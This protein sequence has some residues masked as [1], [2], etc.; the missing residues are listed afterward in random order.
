MKKILLYSLILVSPFLLVIFVNET[1][2]PSE[3]YKISFWDQTAIAYNPKSKD[4]EKC[5]WDCHNNGCSH[6]KSNCINKGEFITGFYQKTLNFNGLHSKENDSKS[7]QG[8]LYKSMNI[9]FLVILWPLFMFALLV[10]NIE[11]FLKRKRTSV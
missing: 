9:V 2:R 7:E 1:N 5:N 11:L 8:M 4:L 3:L 10:V 6:R